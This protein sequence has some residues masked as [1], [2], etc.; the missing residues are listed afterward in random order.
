MREGRA[1]RALAA[2]YAVVAAAQVYL[3]ATTGVVWAV[4]LAT[5]CL[6]LAIGCGFAARNLGR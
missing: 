4:A 2:T 6:A 3:A 5:V 1:W